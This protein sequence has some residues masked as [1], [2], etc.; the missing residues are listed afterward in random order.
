MGRCQGRY[1]QAS[2]VLCLGEATG[3]AVSASELFM[4][5]N[6][7]KPTPIGPLCAEQPEW[8]GY[9]PVALP[10]HR[11]PAERPTT[12]RETCDVLVIGAGIVGVSTAYFL[13]KAGL[14]VAL[15]DQGPANGQA[16]GGNAG[17]LH[18]Q[19]LSFDATE[20]R[21]REGG[22]AVQT[23]ALQ[24]EGIALWQ[25]LETELAADF[26][27]SIT[28]GLMVAEDESQMAFLESKAAVERHQGI[29][30]DLLDGAEL[31]RLA[32]EVSPR[33]VG[34]ALCHGEGKINPLLATPRLLEAARSL[35]VR[36]EAFRRV[37]A[38]E[39]VVAGYEVRA[40]PL[41]YTAGRIVN[42]AGGW[43]PAIAAL[44]GIDLPVKSAPQQMIVTEAAGP[45]VAQLLSHAAR[46]LTMKQAANGNLIIGG[47]WFAGIDRRAGRPVNLRAAI[48]GNLWAA[49]RVVP[50]I[51][52][53]AV[54]RC[55]AVPGVMID[56]APILGP[57]PGHP[58]LYTAVGANG[59]TMGPLMGQ[60][61]A[62]LIAEGR[63]RSTDIIPF[64]L[65]RF[66]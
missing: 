11:A 54:I 24:R 29:A 43:S 30:V 9:R 25:R 48:E 34:A 22:G 1:C 12:R 60:L 35:G 21:G 7:L 36:F 57:A 40:G 14:D 49:R 27:I 19:L 61:T 50:A 53:L 65:A 33:M 26:E 2:A 46:H 59:Y 51:G 58:G 17:S 5:Q 4:P 16:S 13:A 39:R 66:A 32:P 28:G 20:T 52:A 18:L 15:I 3:R 47:G 37:Q 55:W 45:L 10:R 44:A 56:G 62:E 63:C 6:P 42:A 31:R 38:I 23:L 64:L 8:S 41:T